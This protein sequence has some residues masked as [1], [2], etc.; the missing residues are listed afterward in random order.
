[1]SAGVEADVQPVRAP[2]AG[3]GVLSGLAAAVLPFDRILAGMVAAGQGIQAIRLYL[4]LTRAGLDGHLVRLDLPTPHDR[5]PRAPGGRGWS[6]PDTMRLIAWRAAG[7][8]PETI[9]H[10]LGRSASAVRA[11][12]RRLGLPAPARGSVRRVDPSG[13]REPFPDLLPDGLLPDGEAACRATGRAPVSATPSAMC[14]R[15]AGPASVAGAGSA[16]PPVP[17]DPVP[18]EAPATS[19]KAPAAA[20]VGPGPD[21]PAPLRARGSLPP[22]GPVPTSGIIRPEPRDP[23]PP[24]PRT[25]PATEDDVALHGDLTWIGS[26]RQPLQYRSVVWT[27][28]MLYFGGLHWTRIAERIGKTAPATRTLLSRCWVPRDHDRSKFSDTFDE[29]AARATVALAGLELGY[30]TERREH[31]WR[32]RRDRAKVR[33]TRERRRAM[34]LL[35]DHATETVTLAVPSRRGSAPPFARAPAMMPAG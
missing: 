19:A 5:P 28:G 3:L 26:L 29:A 27:L 15:A 8:H 11:R 9:G 12:A 1:M 18:R 13:L 23:P 34:G 35:D 6:A 31:F 2:I 16:L 14:G 10:R 7:V 21:A 30:D 32:F 17:P 24:P 33:Q 22:V 4:G 20:P 25:P